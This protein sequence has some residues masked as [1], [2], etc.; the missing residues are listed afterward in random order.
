MIPGHF[1]PVWVRLCPKTSRVFFAI[2]VDPRTYLG[3]RGKGGGPLPP[4]VPDYGAHNRG[5]GGGV[6][7][8]DAKQPQVFMK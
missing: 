3:L 8:G 4:A 7:R 6:L 1:G 2:Y 5:K